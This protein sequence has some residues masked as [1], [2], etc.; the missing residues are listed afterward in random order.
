MVGEFSRQ[1]RCFETGILFF[2]KPERVGW[3]VCCLVLKEMVQS[4][5]DV[6]SYNLGYADIHGRK[7]LGVCTKLEYLESLQIYI[8]LNGCGNC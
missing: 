8:L 2:I 6:F 4:D 7:S 3:L 5:Q 1:E